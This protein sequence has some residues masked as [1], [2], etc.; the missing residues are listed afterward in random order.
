MPSN[1]VRSLHAA[2]R[3]GAFLIILTL[4]AGLVAGLFV[5]VHF[6]PQRSHGILQPLPMLGTGVALSALALVSTLVCLRFLE[7]RP[8]ATVGLPTGRPMAT[9]ILVGLTLGAIVPLTVAG[10]LWVGGR[11]SILPADLSAQQLLADTLPIVGAT[12]LLA[13]WEEVAFRGYALQLLN[14]LGGPW[15]GAAVTGV[16]FGLA[17]SGNPGANLAGFTYTAVNG[18][19][20]A[21]LVIRTGSLWLACGYHA[22]WNL[23]ALTLL[24]LRDSGVTAP[25]SFL[26]TTLSGPDWLSGGA[27]GFEAS[28]I[29]GVA[30]AILLGILLLSTTHLPQVESARRYFGG[31]SSRAE[32]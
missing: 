12:L 13:T 27:Y 23:A 18:A 29:T 21:G 25:G 11:A 19:L 22:G 4:F 7:R 30:E 26:N 32:R 9:G 16:L 17:H 6:P 24:G 28:V 20:L 3:L 8:L 5:A 31:T 1:P 15:L 14:E 2:W 10:L